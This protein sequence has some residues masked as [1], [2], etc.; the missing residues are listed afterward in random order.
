MNRWVTIAGLPIIFIIGLVSTIDS[1]RSIIALAACAGTALA[2]ARVRSDAAQNTA[3]IRLDFLVLLLPTALALRA[4]DIRIS[5]LAVGLLTAIAFIRKPDGT[6][7]IK[8]GPL[9]LMLAASVI[10][11][12]RH[13]SKYQVLIFFLAGAFTVR[14]AATANS[15]RIIKSLIDACGFY[16]FVN[17]FLYGVGLR[18]IAE[19]SRIGGLSEASGSVRTIYPLTTSLNV[20]PILAA[21]YLATI[22]FQ[23]AKGTPFQYVIRFVYLVSALA[24]IIGAGTRGPLIS[25]AIT[26]LALMA[27]PFIARWLAQTAV[28]F[29]AVSPI[30]LPKIMATMES[31]FTPLVNLITSRS[32]DQ[33]ANLQGREIIWKLSINYW[34][35]WVDDI[36]QLLLG[37]GVDG[38]YRSGIS[39]SYADLLSSIMRSPER[40]YAHNSFLQQLFD[41]GIIGWLLLTLGIYWG[42]IRSSRLLG[43][44]DV[45]GLSAIGATTVLLISGMTEVSLAPGVG[46]ETFWL[47]VI[48]IGVSCQ[49]RRHGSDPS[50]VTK[51]NT[52]AAPQRKRPRGSRP[53]VGVSS[54]TYRRSA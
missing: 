28:L 16:C 19:L 39:S 45:W 23:I 30:V 32:N 2:L 35:A 24:V 7:K 47:M 26:A 13:D 18:S 51:L 12:S 52:A 54:T 14:V 29:A 9:L 36:P 44:G 50:A 41:G 20:P 17:V 37:F 22:V 1:G 31:F 46:Q 6:Y 11:L 3:A 42:C 10:V 4:V 38:Q 40:A 53:L 25:A 15:K 5:V 21:I 49:G 34:S 43:K 33:I 27:L 8:F 48:L